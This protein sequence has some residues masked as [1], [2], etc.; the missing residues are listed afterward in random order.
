MKKIDDL[1]QQVTLA[2]FE[3][4]AAERKVSL[5]EEKIAAITLPT[6]V[7]GI[8][9]RRSAVRAALAGRTEERAKNLVERFSAEDGISPELISELNAILSS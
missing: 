6:C 5:L 1:S 3:L 4:E 9:A 7:E 8:V 2:I